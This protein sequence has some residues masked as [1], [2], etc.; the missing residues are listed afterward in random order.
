MSKKSL[1]AARPQAAAGWP[2]TRTSTSTSIRSSAAGSRTPNDARVINQRAR[3]LGFSTS[4]G[5][6][7][8]GSGL[9]RPLGAVERAVYD[10][11][12]RRTSS[13]A[14]IA[15][16]LYSGIRGF[17]DNLATASRTTGGAARAP[18]I[19]IS[20]KTGSCTGVLNSG[21]ARASRWSATRSRRH[22]PRIH[23]AEMVRPVLHH[24]LRPPRLD[25]GL[26]AAAAAA[27]N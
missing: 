18:G 15:Q 16:N 4:I 22:P 9:L 24:R 26:L 17:Q 5:I 6:I 25:D 7:H 23:D 27:E 8:D 3:E 14:Q 13:V 12:A 19:S 21:A 1:R 20:A 2:S 10:D 11:V